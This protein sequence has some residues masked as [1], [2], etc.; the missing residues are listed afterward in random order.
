[1]LRYA[2]FLAPALLSIAQPPVVQLDPWASDSI[3]V[4]IA[5]T[6]RSIWDPPLRGLLPTPPTLLTPSYGDGSTSLTNGNLRVDVDPTTGFLTATRV[7]DGTLLLK[8]TAL[9]FGTPDVPFT[10]DGSVSASVAFAGTAGERVYG[11]GEHRTGVVNQMPF[12]KRFAD[13]QDYAKSGG[14][15]AMIPF[16]ASSLGYGFLWNNAAYGSASLS[17][18]AIE[19]FANAT[20]GV[21]IWLTT[22]SAGFNPASGRSPFADILSNYVDAV[23]HASRMPFYSTGFI[24]CKDR[25]R[26]QSQLL[27]VARGY[28]ERQLPISVIVIDWM[29]WVV[30]SSLSTASPVHKN[31]DPNILTR[32]YPLPPSQ[33]HKVTGILIHNAGL[34]RKACSTSCRLSGSS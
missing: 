24:Q 2:A 13:S 16:Y 34:T 8:Q 11:L 22:T 21:D 5:P 29:H 17:E 18:T 14:S 33:R 25:Y 15:D 12:T 7:S 19:W 31:P 9:A 6:G 27:D 32:L 23:G 1:M 26:N 28:V 4:R 10:R 30:S 20:L 3:R